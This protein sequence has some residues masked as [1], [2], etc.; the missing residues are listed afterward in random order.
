MVEF[1]ITLSITAVSMYIASVIIPGIVM[2]SAGA[3]FIGAF[4]LGLVNGIIKPILVFFTF[5][6]TIVTLGL[7]LLV[8]NAICFSLVGY[9]T[10]GFKVGGFL[11]ALFGS[12][13]VSVVST[14]INQIV[15]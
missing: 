4:V 12:V 5:P 10:P 14:I 15:F 13:I 2:E 6:I 3:A 9:F 7:F 8:V 1:I 11:N